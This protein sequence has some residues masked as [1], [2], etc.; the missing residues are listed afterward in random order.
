MCVRAIF[1]R[2]DQIRTIAS[3]SRTEQ[4]QLSLLRLYRFITVDALFMK[5]HALSASWIRPVR[6]VLTIAHTWF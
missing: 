2:F 5:I 1:T 6:L 4:F 3:T